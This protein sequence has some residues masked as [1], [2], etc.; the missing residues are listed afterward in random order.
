MQYTHAG[1]TIGPPLLLL[2]EAL[3]AVL[4]AAVA[5]LSSSCTEEAGDVGAKPADVDGGAVKSIAATC[6]LAL[7]D[8]AL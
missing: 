8:A 4:L 2:A 1:Q 5:F 7:I 3:A 6:L